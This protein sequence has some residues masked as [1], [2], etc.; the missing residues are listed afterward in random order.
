MIKNE[1]FE[2]IR[3]EP[4]KTWR[5]KKLKR[6]LDMECMIESLERKDNKK[7]LTTF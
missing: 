3:K 2:Q 5:Y 1:L 4:Y 6:I 7:T